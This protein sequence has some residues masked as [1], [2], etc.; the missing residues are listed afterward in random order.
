MSG[1]RWVL[2][3]ARETT[4]ARMV[5]APSGA[6][7]WVGASQRGY[8]ERGWRRLLRSGLM[9]SIWK[10]RPSEAVHPRSLNAT[11]HHAVAAQR[12]KKRQPPGLR[13]NSIWGPTY[14]LTVSF[15]LGGEN[16]L[17]RVGKFGVQQDKHWCKH[18]F[19]IKFNQISTGTHLFLC[20]DV[21]KMFSTR[22]EMVD[23]QL[24][25]TSQV[26]EQSL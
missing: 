12:S 23:L 8:A 7:V 3:W 10:R 17:E 1:M 13:G 22:W 24:Q 6:I 11:T 19:L 18:F 25:Q 26:R 15:L 21:E 16:V 14:L 9:F 4:K 5:Y 2:R 20:L